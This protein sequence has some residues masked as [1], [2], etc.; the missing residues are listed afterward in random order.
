MNI[1]HNTKSL[2]YIAYIRKS[3]ERE[4]R[5]MLSLS[6]QK[7]EIQKHFPSLNIIEFIE[8]HRSAFKPNNRPLFRRALDRI[9]A[10][11]A[12]GFVGWH[13]NRLSRN[14]IEAAEV[15]YMLRTGGMQDLKFCSFN[16]D[17]SAEGIMMLQMVMSQS[18]YES[19][20][21][22]RDVKRGMEQKV[23]LMKERPGQV[24]QGYR[25]VPVIDAA[26][27]PLIRPKDGKVITKT[28][29]DPERYDMIRKIW[30]M[31]ASGKHTVAEIRTIANKEWQ[32]T[33]RKTAKIGG[34]PL[35]SSMMYKILNNVFYAGMI[36]HNGEVYPGGH[37]P[38]V[39]LEEFDY[40]QKLLGDKGKPR[41]RGDDLAY[42][43]IMVCGECG[44]SIVGECKDKMV[45]STGRLTTYVYYRCTR[46]SDA[47]PCNQ[48]KYT[49]LKELEDQIEA[50]LGK[51]TI[52]PEFRDLAL[53]VLRRNNKTETRSRAH[54]HTSQSK[55]RAELQTQLDKLIDMRTRELIDDEEY[56]EQ[57]NR[58]KLERQH[59]DDLLRTTEVRADEWMELT[60]KAFDFATYA[61]VRF[62]ETTDLKVKRDILLTLGTKLVLR[63]RLLTVEPNEWL[64]PIGEQYSELEKRYLWARTNQKTSSQVK[65]EAL[66]SIFETWRARR[67]LNSRH[68]A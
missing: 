22:G 23:S 33:T 4:D 35:T 40:V 17:N 56:L 20:K 30:T 26:G 13:P 45:K 64:V 44:C 38:M 16:F 62:R 49:T 68:P 53:K 43:S 32:F 57:K 55:R 25:K 12:D 31:L 1:S 47:R 29:I 65:E 8:E 59:V 2:K 48:R 6:A 21:Q 42:A 51:Y 63:D 11:E 28:D 3:E 5:Q 18:Q 60:E 7:A 15:T 46:K 61:Q 41:S 66:D 27:S 54:I 10:G 52:L 24:P 9:K 50:E 58:L 67:D 37:R 14:E 34:K 36:T 39:T 19:S